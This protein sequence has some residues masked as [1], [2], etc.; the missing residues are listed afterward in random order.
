MTDNS[1]RHDSLSN[2]ELVDI[3]LLYKEDVD[4]A[5]LKYKR[6]VN[7]LLARKQEE[8]TA[9]LKQKDDPFGVVSQVIGTY[10]VK[11]DTK[12]KV[13]WDQEKLGHLYEEIKSD[14][15]E[16]VE[17]YIG[18]EY[19]VSETAY[20]NWPAPIR[21]HFEPARTVETG[22]TSVTIEPAKEK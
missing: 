12:K 21:Q 13:T 11:F 19:K 7:T 15:D 14:P 9:S 4:A 10:K 8:I 18:L 1:K 22:S 2:E 20:K 3:I 17:E 5:T 6:V 16:K